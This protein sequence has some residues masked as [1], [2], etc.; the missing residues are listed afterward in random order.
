MLKDLHHE[1]SD[2]AAIR[3]YLDDSVSISTADVY[4]FFKKIVNSIV[5]PVG[6][7]T[8]FGGFLLLILFGSLSTGVYLET[9]IFVGQYQNWHS[10][11]EALIQHPFILV[12]AIIASTM[13][14]V[15]IV[16]REYK[17]SKD[18]KSDVRLRF[19][20]RYQHQFN[21][22][23]KFGLEMLLKTSFS[24][25]FICFIVKQRAKMDSFGGDQRVKLNTILLTVSE[26]RIRGNCQVICMHICTKIRRMCLVDG[27][28]VSEVAREFNVSRTTVYKYLNES[29][30]PV[31]QRSVPIVCPKLESF[32]PQLI[33]W[34][35]VD[36]TRSVR[37]RRTA[38]QL[39]EGI[40]L[41]GYRGAY[42]SVQRFV[43]AWKDQSSQSIKQAYI[44]LIFAPGEACQFDWS[45]EQ[46]ILGGCNVK[47]KLAHFRLCHSRKSYLRAYSRE[48]QEMV[49]DAHIRAFEFFDGLPKKMIY[50]NPKPIVNS[51]LQGKHREFNRRFLSL[52]NHY[53][54]EPIACTPAAGWE[55]GQVERQVGI[56]RQ[57]LFV[58]R[59]TFADLNELNQWLEQRCK[60]MGQRPHPTNKSMLIDE[61][62]AEEQAH[63]R[64]AI[65]AFDGYYERLARVHATCVV[66][67]D[68]NQYSVPC[69]YVGQVVS[70]RAYAT[71]IKVVVNDV[72]VAEHQRS[73]ARDQMIFDPWH[74][75]PVLEIKPGALR[76]GAPFVDWELPKAL[77]TLKARYLKRDGGDREFVQLL[78]L[79]RQHGLETVSVACELALDAKTTQLSVITNL[80]HRL[81][82]SEPIQAMTITD[83]PVLSVPPVANV[84][85]Y[86]Q[87]CAQEVNHA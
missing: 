8:L 29:N 24:I 5:D 32:K 57:R 18:L 6:K 1:I 48:T 87:L 16:Y 82:E 54:I 11:L 46:I 70:V 81:I 14:F 23:N 51:I 75:L 2:V 4:E 86:D 17:K 63:L 84:G 38:V 62:F 30:E 35:E 83:A 79:V 26:L 61:V 34:L 43:K 44:P 73:F 77:L 36:A 58:P 50:D 21:F 64:G 65:V 71:L 10:W 78:L 45:H 52:M 27:R 28:N 25:V 3:S 56:M 80:V 37:A 31:Y 41:Q 47:I 60:Q 33:E 22:E 55:K 68:R 7:P 74:Y 19:L 85:R 20:L 66:H 42:D 40:Q 72:V 39:Y 15:L 12:L 76:N 59:S 69:Q 53:L 67:Y 13:T 9:G 49:F